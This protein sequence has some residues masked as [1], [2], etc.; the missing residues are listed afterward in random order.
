MTEEQLPT[1]EVTS[2]AKEEAKTGK[3][4]N[5]PDREQLKAMAGASFMKNR[6]IFDD[7]F[8]TLSARAKSRVMHAVLDMPT[9]G[10]PVYLKTDDEKQAFALGQRIISDR[11]IITYYHIE[12]ESK[13]AKAA[14]QKKAEEEAQENSEENIQKG[15]DDAEANLPWK[16]EKTVD[17]SPDS[18]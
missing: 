1:T 13:A 4:V 8:K 7:I 3:K 11:F 12:E 10:M 18:E 15:L 5:M 2:V 6:K 16:D 14:E 17:T 9:G